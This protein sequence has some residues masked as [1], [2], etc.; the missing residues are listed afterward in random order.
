MSSGGSIL[1]WLPSNW[2][3]LLLY[4][5]CEAA[6]AF[7]HTPYENLE[8]ITSLFLRFKAKHALS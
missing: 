2:Q 4:G 6:A 7:A 5:L 1:G 8:E 3:Q